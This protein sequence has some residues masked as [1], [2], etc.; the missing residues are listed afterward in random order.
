MTSTHSDPNTPSTPDTLSAQR[1][2]GIG[3]WWRE[4]ETAAL[5]GTARRT[6]PALPDL[7]AI[8][9][10]DRPAGSPEEALLDAAA[11]GGALRRT[12]RRLSSAGPP[13]Q[14]P[15]ESRPVA[16]ARAVQLLELVLDQPPAGAQQRAQLLGRW[17]ECAE[18]SRYRLPPVLLPRVL[19]LATA[20]RS[21]RA[22]TAAVVGERGRWLAGLRRPWAWAGG[23]N[24]AAAERPP[25]LITL[26]GWARLSAAARP[27][28]LSTVRSADPVLARELIA[29]T[30]NTDAARERRAQ[31]DLLRAGL[32]A[33]DEP[34][35]EQALDDR[36]GTV[37]DLA[38]ELLEQLPTSAR[39]RR[40][41]DRLRPLVRRRG[42]LGRTVE[43]ELPGDPDPAGVRDGLGRPPAQRSARGWWLE[44]ICAGAPL[45][46]WAELVRADPAG[47]VRRVGDPD[48]RLG[49]V[50][51]TRAQQDPG[52]ASALLAQSWDASL[53][54]A[55]PTADRERAVLG[56]LETTDNGFSIEAAL[57]R[58]EVPWSDQF[59]RGLLARL[60]ASKEPAGLVSITMTH[61]A[62]GL[63]ESCLPDL[64][65]WLSAAGNE[66]NLTTNL[67]HL[68]QLL[69]VR[70]SIAEAF[71]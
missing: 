63:A 33:E 44:Q 25:G 52:W 2:P 71:L 37:R 18:R 5:L 41:A 36:A 46:L 57:R 20:D 62:D 21:L 35:L 29:S 8:G 19:E 50:R 42:L 31:L 34:L 65:A 26:Q 10:D 51:A 9:V 55:L 70:R 23:P 60:R 12:G 54:S 14:A 66:R 30:W 58:L 43:I 59:G 11:L 40:M 47:V 3:E 24:P 39:A 7:S 69:S 28:V 64:E 49:L 32:G 17:L 48:A 56:C 15:A 61:L 53:L 16:P 27:A 6:V 38:A 45:S 22:R 67:R 4:V 68:L 1:R 13:D